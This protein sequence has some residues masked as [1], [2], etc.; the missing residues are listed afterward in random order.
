MAVLM[1][2]STVAHAG[3]VYK[4]IM[5]T[6][7]VMLSSFDQETDS[8]KRMR[9][10]V[11]RDP[12]PYQHGPHIL[13]IPFFNNNC[14]PCWQQAASGKPRGQ[15]RS[16]R[17]SC[18]RH[19]QLNTARNAIH[20][21]SLQSLGEAWNDDVERR[22]CRRRANG[23]IKVLRKKTPTAPLPCRCQK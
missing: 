22:Q 19:F 16:V 18:P 13:G 1:Y 8:A 20:E 17:S 4:D 10:A 6:L 15:Y 3:K 7:K 9:R 2:L 23:Y 11:P 5:G 12:P 14:I 21:F